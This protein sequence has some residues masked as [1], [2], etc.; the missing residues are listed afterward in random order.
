MTTLIA[1]A[2]LPVPGKVKTRLA[3]GCSPDA[4][5]EFY[6]ASL[7]HC[8]QEAKKYVSFKSDNCMVRKWCMRTV[9][10]AGVPRPKAMMAW[11]RMQ[12]NW[13]EWCCRTRHPVICCCSEDAE[14]LGMQDWLQSRGL[15]GFILL[16]CSRVIGCKCTQPTSHATTQDFAAFSA[17]TA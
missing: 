4:A 16:A 5:C 14:V 15:V 3:A 7:E 1:F 10:Q 13:A 12:K 2:R 11:R 8:L 6:S 9:V 17:S